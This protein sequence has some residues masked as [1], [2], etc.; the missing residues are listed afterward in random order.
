M[1]AGVRIRP[2]EPTDAELLFSLIVELAGYEGLADKVGGDAS[3]FAEWLFGADPAVEALVAELEGEPVG[4]ALFYRTFSTFET[5]P[6]L[7]LEDLF[8]RERARGRGVGR[9]L[10]EE[11]ARV[12]VER[13]YTR[14]EWVALD[15]NAQAFGF[16]E[17][18]GARRLDEWKLLRLDG[19]TL[20]RVAA[21]AD[22]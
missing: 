8:V 22:S 10:L 1:T 20:A 14:L 16:Y 21:A 4:W 17:Q 6:G 18:L 19:E 12:T 2:A 3:L 13:G 7:W 5:K 11:L 15:W 9:A